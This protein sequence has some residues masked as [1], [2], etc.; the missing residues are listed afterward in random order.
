MFIG[1]LRYAAKENMHY[2]RSGSKATP[3][4]G[5]AKPRPWGP[6]SFEP[7][8]DGSSDSDGGHEFFDVAIEACG[9]PSPVFE[10]TEHALDDVALLVDFGGAIELGVSVACLNPLELNVVVDRVTLPNAGKPD[11]LGADFQLNWI[12]DAKRFSAEIANDIARAH[13]N[14]LNPGFPRTIQNFRN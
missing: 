8:D 10:A 9:D 1:E 13:G 6:D 2:E 4:L 11:P 14:L 7:P 12:G 3:K 5:L